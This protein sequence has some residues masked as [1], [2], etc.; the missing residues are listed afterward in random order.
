MS[1]IKQKI[2]N[3][4]LQE[5]DK[6]YI[7]AFRSIQDKLYIW[8]D[9]SKTPSVLQPPV[10]MI[11]VDYNTGNLQE[12]P[13]YA[14]DVQEHWVTASLQ[15]AGKLG[16]IKNS[17]RHGKGNF[18]GYLGEYVFADP[19]G[20]R[21]VSDSTYDYDVFTPHFDIDVKTKE[22]SGI[23]EEYYACSVKEPVINKEGNKKYQNCSIYVFVRCKQKQG[24]ESWL[25]GYMFRDE[26]LQKAFKGEEGQ[27]EDTPG[28]NKD[29]FVYRADCLNV[30]IKDLRKF[31]TVEF[32]RQRILTF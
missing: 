28:G 22:C 25:L 2:Q 19:F 12:H 23:P 27:V 13:L 9:P 5:L 20:Y 1:V 17:I 29:I 4:F 8:A 7:R 6:G 3:W 32:Q 30:L 26:F 16:E 18:I 24:C 14:V 21:I 31:K 10:E 15:K 11:F